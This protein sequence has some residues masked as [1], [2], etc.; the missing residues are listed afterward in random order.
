MREYQDD[1]RHKIGVVVV[2]RRCAHR[3]NRSRAGERDA[4]VS[5][6]LLHHAPKQM[7]TQRI[8][9]SMLFDC[10]SPSNEVFLMDPEDDTAWPVSLRVVMYRGAHDTI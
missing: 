4:S 8:S 9:P 1:F 2:G 6:F 3:N 10:I 5:I 7:C